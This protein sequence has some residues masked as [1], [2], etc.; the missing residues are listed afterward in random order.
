MKKI[1]LILLSLL[2]AATFGLDAAA[3]DANA[4]GNN[5]RKGAITTA[6]ADDE[7]HM[8]YPAPK[9]TAAGVASGAV[10]GKTIA[11]IAGGVVLLA[12]A[13]HKGTSGT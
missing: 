12:V 5:K 3:A 9:P 13:T 4:T 11:Y 1:A 8:T 10:S 6:A 7:P 2:F